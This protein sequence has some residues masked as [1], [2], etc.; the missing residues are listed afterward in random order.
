MAQ[1][2][3]Q[4]RQVHIRAAVEIA[5]ATLMWDAVTI[6]VATATGE[7]IIGIRR[8]ARAAVAAPEIALV[9]QTTVSAVCAGSFVNSRT[10]LHHVNLG[11]EAGGAVHGMKSLDATVPCATARFVGRIMLEELARRL[12]RRA[13]WAVMSR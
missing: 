12:L 1:Q 2:F 13:T 11:H 5:V 6:A 9:G 4:I 7:W 3:G 10:M 8:H